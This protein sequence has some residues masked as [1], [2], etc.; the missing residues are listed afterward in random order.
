MYVFRKIC[1]LCF[2]ETPALRFVLLPY[3]RRIERILAKPL[4]DVIEM[5]MSTV[6]LIVQLIVKLFCL[7]S[8]LLSDYDLNCLKS[9]YSGLLSFLISFLICFSL[10]SSF[11]YILMPCNS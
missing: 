11:S 2:F 8:I 5:F 3:Y 4:L 7:L 9:R 6:S 1:V 10:L